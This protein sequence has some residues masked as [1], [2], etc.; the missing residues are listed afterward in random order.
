MPILFQIGHA[1]AAQIGAHEKYGHIAATLG[2][3]NFESRGSKGVISGD[4]A[5]GAANHLF[6]QHFHMVLSDQEARAALR[7]AKRCV[8]H[9]YVLGQ[10]P[11]RHRGGD[12]SGFMSG[13]ICRAKGM[14]LARLFTTANFVDRSD[15]LGFKTTLGGGQIVR[16]GVSLTGKQDRP[17]PGQIIRT[18]S[19]RSRNIRWIQSRLNFAF[20]NDIPGVGHALGE[21]GNFNDHTKIG[22]KA[23]QL[24]FVRDVDGQVGPD[25]W[26]RLNSLR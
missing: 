16:P 12:C 3:M 13:I 11:T 10:V 23:F 24:Q 25:T 20:A 22:V 8:G 15:N 7:Y 1:T 2:G 17:F 18:G 4:A 9:G 6:K 21:T 14:E 5:R 26:G 19:P